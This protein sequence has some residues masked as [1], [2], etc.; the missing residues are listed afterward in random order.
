LKNPRAW[1]PPPGLIWEIII[2]DE[3]V[4][5]LMSGKIT[6]ITFLLASELFPLFSLSA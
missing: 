3:E 2:S 6:V 4:G 1:A 5:N